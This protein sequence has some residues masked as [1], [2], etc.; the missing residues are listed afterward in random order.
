MR[1][2]PGQ[3][4]AEQENIP[5]SARTTHGNVDQGKAQ[6]AQAKQHQ[7]IQ[8]DLPRVYNVTSIHKIDIV[9]L[10]D[11]NNKNHTHVIYPTTTP[12]TQRLNLNIKV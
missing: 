9:F 5:Q 11:K 6:P 2:G 10:N 4:N 1:T 7:A 12:E 3:K 8:I